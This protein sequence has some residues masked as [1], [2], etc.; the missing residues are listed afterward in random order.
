MFGGVERK[1]VTT[2]LLEITRQLTR[3]S[4]FP[5]QTLLYS[6]LEPTIVKIPSA[7]HKGIHR[8]FGRLIRRKMKRREFF[9]AGA[10]AYSQTIAQYSESAKEGGT[11][12]RSASRRGIEQWH[13]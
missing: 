11:A 1:D 5:L 2:A 7:P 10:T 3:C 4:P 8:E 12:Y 13:R 9:N 6:Y